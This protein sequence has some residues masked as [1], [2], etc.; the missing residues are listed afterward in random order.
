MAYGEAAAFFRSLKASGVNQEKLARQIDP[1]VD[2]VASTGRTT[3]QSLEVHWL[4][5]LRE[6]QDNNSYGN[7]SSPPYDL[8]LNR[9]NGTTH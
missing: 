2:K 8:Y 3:Q 4:N 7:W 5:Y 6:I 9:F 1:S